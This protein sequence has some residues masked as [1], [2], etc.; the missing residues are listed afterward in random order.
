MSWLLRF[1]ERP[2]ACPEK[3]GS[4]ATII[5]VPERHWWWWWRT[6]TYV[7]TDL[8]FWRFADRNMLWW[9]HP[10]VQP[11]GLRAEL[12]NRREEWVDG[13]GVHWKV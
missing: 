9:Y 4:L 12:A 6:V 11:R 3:F 1:G 2:L 7:V 13:L 10:S 5:A 8:G